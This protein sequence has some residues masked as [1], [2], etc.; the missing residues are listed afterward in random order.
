[1][2]QLVDLQKTVLVVEDDASARE[3]LTALLRER[4]YRVEVAVNG[5]QALERLRAG[6]RPDLVL[7][8]MLMPVLDGWLFLRILRRE[9]K[10][11]PVPIIVATGTILT[12]EWAQ[13]HDC[14]GF[15]RKPF[16]AEPL[17]GEVRRCLYEDQPPPDATFDSGGR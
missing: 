17:L 11:P 7:L 12:R 6:P 5:R 14:Q 15:V 10:P 2:E 13:D 1:M 8:D 9:E 3:W 16:D 4:G